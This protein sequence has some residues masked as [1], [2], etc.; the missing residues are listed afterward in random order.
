MAKRRNF[1][2]RQKI[3]I[4]ERATIDGVVFCEGCGVMVKGK[5]FQIDHIIAEALRTPED[6]AKKLTIADGQLLCSG[7]SEACHD[8]KT[9]KGDVPAIAKAVSRQAA[10]LGVSTPTQNPI[11][12]RGFQPTTKPLKLPPKIADGLSGIFRQIR[13][14]EKA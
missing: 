2:E 3:E 1:S 12:S 14:I 8:M 6:R 13:E 4:V 11:Q 7:S 5:N 10:H 9:Q